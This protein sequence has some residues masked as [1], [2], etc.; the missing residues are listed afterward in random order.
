MELNSKNL[1]AMRTAFNLKF[2]EGVALYKPL[3]KELSMV[4]GDIAHDAIEFPF[5]DGIG[6]MREW[7]GD[8]QYKNLSTKSIRV[9]ERPFELS[10]GIKRRAI[11]T[12]NWGIYGRVATGMGESSERLWD[13]LMI[14]AMTDPEPWLDGKAF[15][16]DNRKYGDGKRAGTVVNTANLALSF[17]NFGTFFTQMCSN[18]GNDGIPLDARPTHLIVGPALE[19]TAKIIMEQDHYRDASNNEV[20]NPHKG[21]CKIVVHPLLVG[22]CA[23]DWYLGKFDG[24]MKPLLTMKNKQGDVV[25]LD[26]DKD[27][28]VFDRD[29]VV[30]GTASYGEGAAL[31]PHLLGRSRP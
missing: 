12:D 5:L 15:Y 13:E 17:A 7:L 31:F 1:Q 28:S 6:K 4:E 23:N 16:C 20:L 21:K 27:Q 9:K 30:F 18:T 8:R 19:D 24:V 10:I 2:K 11:E 3:Y 29:E 26:A 22:T 14:A 25:I